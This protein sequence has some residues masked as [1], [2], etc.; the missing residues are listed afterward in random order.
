MQPAGSRPQVYSL[1]ASPARLPHASPSP[2]AYACSSSAFRSE[3]RLGRSNMVVAALLRQGQGGGG[4][5]FTRALTIFEQCGVLESLLIC[6]QNPG[7][8]SYE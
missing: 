4:F 5:S 2:E 7:P 6:L 8:R 3:K 1:A